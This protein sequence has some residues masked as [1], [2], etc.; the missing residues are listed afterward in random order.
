MADSEDEFYDSNGDFNFPEAAKGTGVR[1]QTRGPIENEKLNVAQEGADVGEY[2]ASLS[3][4]SI[5]WNSSQWEEM[6]KE[7]EEM[8]FDTYLRKS[9]GTTKTRSGTAKH[10]ATILYFW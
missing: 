3:G 7:L 2:Y 6:Q 5:G 8:E 4:G 9:S 1:G 10:A